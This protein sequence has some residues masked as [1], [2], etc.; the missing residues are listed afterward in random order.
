MTT[1]DMQVPEGWRP[2]PGD[3]LVGTV[4]DVDIGW[5]DFRGEY[6][7]LTIK[8][9]NGTKCANTEPGDT[10]KVHC[11]HDVLFSR[12]ATL[13]PVMGE[14][15][16]VQFHGQQPHKT[17]PSQTVSHYTFKVQGRGADAAALYDRLGSG[18]S[19]TPQRQQERQAGQGFQSRADV[20]ADTRD[21]EPAGTQGTLDQ[22]DDDI[23][24]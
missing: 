11:F 1:P 16:G 21:F 8:A 5:S 23:P 9:G 12:V 6:P 7:I 19:R 20:P 24:F 17:K 22:G 15:V 13:R 2:E 4:E 14:T 3:V 10:V 18:R